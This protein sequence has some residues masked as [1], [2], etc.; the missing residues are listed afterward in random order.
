[1]KN[2]KSSQ[3]DVGV[4]HFGIVEVKHPGQIGDG[5]AGETRS[6][7]A[8]AT[9]ELTDSFPATAHRFHFRLTW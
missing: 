4:D 7:E 3:R 5:Q 9:A 6:C 8:G 1:V 2:R